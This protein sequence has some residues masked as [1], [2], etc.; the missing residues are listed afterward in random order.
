MNCIAVKKCKNLDGCNVGDT[1][2][3]KLDDCFVGKAN[4][5]EIS[6]KLNLVGIQP[7]GELEK[8]VSMNYKEKYKV[9]VAPC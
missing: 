4:I 7:I 8:Y 1:I 5:V 2:I 9:E 3:V 6:S